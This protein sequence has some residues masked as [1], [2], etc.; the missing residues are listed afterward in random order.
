MYSV[1][2]I[3]KLNIL[4]IYC[5]NIL[6]LLFIC[7]KGQDDCNIGKISFQANTASSEL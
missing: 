1:R 3:V 6:F 7:L 2:N 5:I 4:F